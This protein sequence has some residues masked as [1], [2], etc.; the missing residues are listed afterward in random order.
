MLSALARLDVVTVAPPISGPYTGVPDRVARNNLRKCFRYTVDSTG[1][2][3]TVS[4]KMIAGKTLPECS[5]TLLKIGILEPTSSHSLRH[6]SSGRCLR[7]HHAH[8][9]RVSVGM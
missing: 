5:Q 8:R 3:Y 4:I 7:L 1:P 6:S 9:G 2:T